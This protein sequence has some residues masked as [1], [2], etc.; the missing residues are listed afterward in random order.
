VTNLAI[1]VDAEKIVLGGGYLRTREPLLSR[2]RASL[3]RHV[4]YPPRLE[5]GRFGSNG[6]L[7]GALA[8][9]ITAAHATD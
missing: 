4:P 5:I 2:L 1:L 6:G 7:S 3:D 8:L 9:A